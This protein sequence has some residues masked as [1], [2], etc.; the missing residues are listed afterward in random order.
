MKYRIVKHQ[1]KTISNKYDDKLE[2]QVTKVNTN[3]WYIASRKGRIFG[4]WH[5]KK[6]NQLCSKFCNPRIG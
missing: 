5:A 2:K 3:T 4:F 6:K 1:S